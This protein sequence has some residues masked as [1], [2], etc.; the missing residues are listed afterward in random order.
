MERLS[1]RDRPTDA[2]ADGS[3]AASDRPLSQ[4]ALAGLVVGIGGIAIP[5][6]PLMPIVAVVLGYLAHR[7]IRL[8]APVR[9]LKLAVAAMLLG[10]A[11]LLVQGIAIDWFSAKYRSEVESRSESSIDAVMRASQDGDGDAI[12]EHW[13]GRGSTAALRRLGAETLERYG[14][15]KGV[16]VVKWTYGGGLGDS[17]LTAAVVWDF[18]SRR[19][20]G[21]FRMEL[22]PGTTLSDPFP[23][24]RPAELVIS[25]DRL[26][27]LRV[28]AGAS[29][30]A[31]AA[32]DVPP[33]PPT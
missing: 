18:E 31:E 32:D 27:D 20:T 21:S 6:C 28:P 7:R 8:G 3:Q 30:P 11:G 4:L 16:S 2:P 26:G 25:D 23:R 22:V 19:L 9:G 33:D 1:P 12:A 24:P 29:S 17:D 15:F 14:T 10:G 5:C 13:G